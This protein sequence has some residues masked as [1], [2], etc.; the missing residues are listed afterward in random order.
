MNT[1]FKYGP[2]YAYIEHAS[3]TRVVSR[4][5]AESG[6][7]PCFIWISELESFTFSIRTELEEIQEACMGHIYK[8]KRT[9]IQGIEGGREV[10]NQRCAD[11]GAE[12]QRSS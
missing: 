3:Q 5:R 7:S 9:L 8:E 1:P 6:M 2:Y 12:K 4:R 10:Q 11:S